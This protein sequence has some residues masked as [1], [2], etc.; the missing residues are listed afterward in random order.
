M[1]IIT[2]PDLL[3]ELKKISEERYYR[4]YNNIIFTDY[5]TDP[6]FT[7]LS[8][9]DFGYIH[10]D[11][12]C[13]RNSKNR[14]YYYC[15]CNYCGYPTIIK[16]ESLSGG[17]TI[18]CGCLKYKHNKAHS[19]IYKIRLGMIYRCY[20]IKS[21]QYDIYGGRGIKICEEWL[22]DE[23]GFTNFYKWALENGYDD[24]LTIDRIDV[25]G[26]YCPENC[27]WVNYKDQGN[28]RS[29]C[30]YILYKD[31]AFPITIW[32]EIIN[33]NRYTLWDRF[34]NGWST[35]N[36]L[37]TPT[38]NPPGSN[39]I[40]IIVPEKYQVYNKYNEFKDKGLLDTLKR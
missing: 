37:R 33:I 30:H 2:D 26:N 7:D 10:V 38:G 20:D 1:A 18:A 31:Y 29:T 28:N 15:T 8:G 32:G 17:Q 25:D 13:G 12:Y 34:N 35:E 22:N 9:Q 27:R 3:E 5:P 36:A 6:K 16:G 24:T 14:I 11:K 23:N 39:L 19:R 4:I 40:D 21:K